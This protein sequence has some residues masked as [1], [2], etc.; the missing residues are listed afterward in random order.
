MVAVVIGHGVK[1]LAD[2]LASYGADK[3]VV[4]DDPAL[5]AYATEAYARALAQAIAGGEAV[6]SCSFP[7]RPWARTWRPRVAARVGAG[8]VSDCVA[9]SLKDGRLEARRPVYAGKAF[10]TVRWTGEPQMATL[11]PN[12]FALGQPDAG[13]QGRGRR[14]HR[15][16]HG[17]RAGHGGHGHRGGQGRADR[18]PGRSS[19]AAAA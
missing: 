16:R 17:P 7:S 8:L 12:V 19:P 4:F 9:L 13:P 18:G 11:R 15:R 5:A 1:A 2:E 10:A 14:G 3:V 6:A